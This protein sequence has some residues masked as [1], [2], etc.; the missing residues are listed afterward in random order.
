MTRQM[1]AP[2]KFACRGVTLVELIAFIV[3]MGVV[4]AAMVNAFSGTSRGA[5][6]GKQ[7]THAKQLAQERLEVVAG[8]R[9]SLGYAGFTAATYDP[10]QLAIAPWPATQPCAVTAYPAGPF[11]VTSVGNFA[12]DACGAGTGTDCRQI[13]IT[14]TGPYGDVLSNLTYQA[15]NY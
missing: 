7:L 5:H 15:W 2:G 6:Y 9:K 14:V 13:T 12:A 3:I 4:T 10:C 8:Q 11:A 1:T